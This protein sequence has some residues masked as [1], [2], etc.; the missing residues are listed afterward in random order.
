MFQKFLD[1]E[2]NPETRHYSRVLTFDISV[3]LDADCNTFAF[4]ST[5]IYL[6]KL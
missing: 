5:G 4:G 2:R 3:S 1:T 6:L